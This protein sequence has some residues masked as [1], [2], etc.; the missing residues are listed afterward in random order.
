MFCKAP[1]PAG[2][3]SSRASS[4]LAHPA[5]PKGLWA[6]TALS[7][8]ALSQIMLF[9]DGMMGVIQHLATVQ[10]LY[11]LTG[12]LVSGP[13]P[14]ENVHVLLAQLTDGPYFLLGACP[15]CSFGV[16][17]FCPQPSRSAVSL[18]KEGTAAQVILSAL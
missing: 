3:P 13:L 18:G 6:L 12:S 14:A 8:P 16:P 7:H 11:T 4:N 10:W 9:V 2:T 15:S 1:P 5:P 17:P